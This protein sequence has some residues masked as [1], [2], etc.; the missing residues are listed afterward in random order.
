MDT[1]APQEC[2]NDAVV[3]TV[4]PMPNSVFFDGGIAFHQGYLSVQSHGC[5]HLS[6][7]ASEVFFDN[8]VLGDQI[9]VFGAEPY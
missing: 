6:G 5:L 7:A 8:L 2:E 9:V 1:C 4:A 3:A